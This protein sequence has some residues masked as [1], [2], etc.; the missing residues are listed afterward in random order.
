MT[1]YTENIK[2]LCE[3]NS[4]EYYLDNNKV[5]INNDFFGYI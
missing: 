4:I 1:I 3:L 2:E 5:L